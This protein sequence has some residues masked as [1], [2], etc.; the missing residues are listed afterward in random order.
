[1]RADLSRVSFDARKRFDG[2]V[3]EQ[4][5]VL[6]DADLNEESAIVRDRAQT[7]AT[8]VIGPAGV[9][10]DGG[11][12][13]IS[14]TA[15]G[16]DLVVSAGRIHVGGLTLHHEPPAGT[17][18]TVGNRTVDG[19]LLGGPTDDGRYLAVLHAVQREVSVLDDP[20]IAESALGGP[21]TS[22]RIRT[23]WRVLLARIGPVGTGTCADWAPPPRSGDLRPVLPPSAVPTGD[24]ALPGD[25]GFTG[26]E[27]SLYRVEIDSV[28][29]VT[30]AV[31]SLLWDRDNA[32]VASLVEKVGRTVT[33][34]D[35]GPDNVRGFGAGQTVTLTDRRSEEAGTR[36][37]VF[38]TSNPDRAASTLELDATPTGIDENDR[39]RLRRWSGRITN[40]PSGPF[41]LELGLWI[42]LSGSFRPGDYW[43]IPARSSLGAPGGITWPIASSGLFVAL[44]PHG[45]DERWAPLAVADRQNGAWTVPS[46]GDCRRV[47]P[48]LT[49]L[50]A[51]DV[52]Y[53]NTVTD[54]DADTVQEAIERLA[55]QRGGGACTVAVQPGVGWEAPLQALAAGT[56]AR[57]CFLPGDFP[58]AGRVVLTGLGDVVIQGAGPGSVVH[59]TGDEAVLVLEGCRS[60][61][62][63]DIEFA[64]AGRATTAAHDGLSGALTVRDCPQVR[65]SDVTARIEP[66]RFPRGTCITVA[67]PAASPQGQAR[68]L[69]RCIVR[70]CTLDVGDR[71]TGLLIRGFPQVDVS[72]IVAAV[73][74]PTGIRFPD[75]PRKLRPQ[76]RRMLVERLL[77]EAPAPA[78][79]G[80][81]VN[82][83]AGPLA[84]NVVI[85]GLGPGQLS[86]RTPGFLAQPWRNLLAM[87]P[88]PPGGTGREL[89]THVQRLADQI[90]RSGDHPELDGI[91]ELLARR[92]ETRLPSM[93]K[94]IVVVSTVLDEVRVTRC[95]VVDATIGITV[96]ADNAADGPSTGAARRISVVD[97]D[98]AVRIPLEGARTRHGIFLG[99]GLSVLVADNRVSVTDDSLRPTEQKDG[100][101]VWGVLGRYLLVRDNH[102]SGAAPGVRI[103]PVDRP[104]TPAEEGTSSRWVVRDNYLEGNPRNV[105]AV[106][107]ASPATHGRV[108][109][110]GN[111]G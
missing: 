101:K 59:S 6:L 29:T 7:T 102:L 109:L 63:R 28:D 99:N 36:A 34:D 42:E 10:R 31:T 41:E 65:I 81:V 105:V 97:N 74:G 33:L 48:A 55:V 17:E 27:N 108:Q 110:I 21:S 25:A 75:F 98:V 91:R 5:R 47:F 12:F 11:G 23:F 53:D 93:A 2:V 26:L 52:S 3:V 44:P 8:D 83:F 72:G 39:P 64:A 43:L 13:A 62:V 30:G 54:L 76:I 16:D 46:D 19:R 60:V 9:P 85:P 37:A 82:P 84:P 106:Y 111:S 32:S 95:R 77:V 89:R 45:P 100:I 4:G 24:C 87:R 107:P 80:P 94:G 71:Q 66:G 61:T 68:T 38:T 90:L 70:D 78:P 92:G 79:P 103:A 58:T 22:V 69:A 51:A 57:I 1:M 40:P 15:A 14:A 35:F 73:N 56:D 104:P 67:G 50:T 49:A 86:F 18:V 20:S 88:P 96:A